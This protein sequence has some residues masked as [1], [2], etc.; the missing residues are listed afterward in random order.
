VKSAKF[1]I[2]FRPSVTFDA[3]WLRNEAT[4]R[5]TNLIWGTPMNVLCRLSKYGVDRSGVDLSV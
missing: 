2:D 1:G 3:P 5:K 4:D